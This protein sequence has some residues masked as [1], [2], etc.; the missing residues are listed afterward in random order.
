MNISFRKL[1]HNRLIAGT[2]CLT[3]SGILCRGMGFF[4]R[5]FLSRTIG[6]QGL[7]LYQLVTPVLFLSISFVCA[8]IS[9]TISRFVSF[10]PKKA[11]IYF[12]IGLTCSLGLSILCG[13]LLYMEADRIAFL[14]LKDEAAAP[15]I[16]IIGYSLVPS[17]FHNCIN[18]YCYGKKKAVLPSVSQVIEQA[19]RIIGVYLLYRFVTGEGKE[20]TAAI[21]AWGILIGEVASFITCF[22]VVSQMKKPKLTSIKKEQLH[23]F[24]EMAVPLTTNQLLSHACSS[25]EFLLIPQMLVVY[26]YTKEDALSVF[27]VLTGMSLA[28]IV[29]PAVLV[30]SLCVM[31]LPEVAGAKG[32]RNPQ[33]LHGLLHKILWFGLGFGILCSLFFLFSKNYIANTLF[34]N[35][36]VANYLSRLS[37][38][39]PLLYIESLL[40]SILNGQNHSKQVLAINL[41]SCAI[42][43]GFIALGIPRFGLE[44]YIWGMIAGSAVTVVLQLLTLRIP[45]ESPM[46]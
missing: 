38:L 14:F 29:C 16:K 8:G 27:G 22:H 21:A 12:M 32:S 1:I 46:K 5:I 26:G 40:Q 25:I 33:T 4:Y 35:A 44:A 15:L 39:C 45:K 28:V 17:A 34:Q 41:F 30:N 36:L 7:G 6:A 43:I 23:S 42:R 24:F 20:F 31:L 10:E 9:T 18:G 19:S 2:L 3:I 13:T 11:N 37:F